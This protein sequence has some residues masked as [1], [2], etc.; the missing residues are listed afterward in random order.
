MTDWLQNSTEMANRIRHHD[1]ANTSL[2]P[3][4][5]WPDVL[6]TT[7]SLT[8]ASHFPQ[9]IVWGPELITLY[10]DAFVPILG[11]KPEALGRAFSD[12]WAE[13]WSYISPIADVAFAGQATYIEDFALVITRGGGPEKAYFTFCYS[14][15]RDSFGNVVGMLDTVT[16]TTQTVYL[17]QRLA[18]LDAINNAVTTATDAQTILAATTRLLAP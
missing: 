11:S 10:N 6:K 1:W 15:I 12:V 7:V 18:V 14:P 4:A 13:A 3:L 2:G 17:N 5:D 16:E 8:L 9:A